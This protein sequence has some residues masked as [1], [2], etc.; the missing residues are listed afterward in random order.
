MTPRPQPTP[1]TLGN[2]LPEHAM[3]PNHQTDNSFNESFVSKKTDPL[4]PA[5]F[6]DFDW[7]AL[8]AEFGEAEDSDD[9]RQKLGQALRAILCFLLDVDLK[10]KSSKDLVYRR[11]ISFAWAVDPSLLEGKSITELARIMRLPNKMSLARI[12]SQ[13]SKCFGITNRAQAHGNHAKRPHNAPDDC[14]TSKPRKT[15]SGSPTVKHGRPRP[16]KKQG[17]ESF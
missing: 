6:C 16:A 7:Q 14:G 17:K 2:A 5:T 3:K 1:R 15:A 12:T 13:T 10:R 4:A 8:Y 11:V 9:S